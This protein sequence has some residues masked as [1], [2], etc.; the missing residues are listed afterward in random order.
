MNRRQAI[1][2]AIAAGVA[3]IS[4]AALTQVQGAETSDEPNPDLEKVKALLQAHDDA[5]TEHDLAGVLATFDDDAALMGTG[6][7]EMWQGKE[8]LKVA[9]EHFFMVFDKTNQ[10]FKYKFRV[11][12]LASET[13]WLMASGD[14]VGKRDG[15][16]FSYPLNISLV[17]DK[18]GENWKITAMHFSTLANVKG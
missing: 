4:A 17:V 1:A 6:P 18:S 11:G 13:G 15:K 5:M 10:D 9:Y 2:Q 8:E 12:G 14:V 7:G 16:D 3:G